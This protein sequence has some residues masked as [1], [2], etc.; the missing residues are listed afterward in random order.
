MRNPTKKFDTLPVTPSTERPELEALLGWFFSV[1]D[2]RCI[3]PYF[4]KLSARQLRALRG[5]DAC[6]EQVH[7]EIRRRLYGISNH[8]AGVLQA[9]FA[10]RA[11]PKGLRRELGRLTGTIVRLA[12]AG[13]W[14]EETWEQDLLEM[15]VAVQLDVVL[16]EA[17]GAFLAAYRASARALLRQALVAYGVVPGEGERS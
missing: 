16:A 7:R 6:E 11:W 3:K 1:D 17:G 2:G 5:P 15:R 9:A 10:P 8:D 13:D 12:S 4:D 14:P